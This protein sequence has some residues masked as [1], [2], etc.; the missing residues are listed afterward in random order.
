MVR[1]RGGSGVTCTVLFL[2]HCTLMLRSS[3]ARL[4]T[5]SNG[6]EAGCAGLTCDNAGEKKTDTR[7]SV[8][9]AY[10]AQTA[11]TTAGKKEDTVFVRVRGGGCHDYGRSKAKRIH[12]RAA[13]DAGQCAT[14][15]LGNVL[16]SLYFEYDAGFCGCGELGGNECQGPDMGSNWGGSVYRITSYD[17]SARQIPQ[18]RRSD[19]NKQKHGSEGCADDRE[20]CKLWAS[21]GECEKNP[22]YMKATC[23]A[24][25]GAPGCPVQAAPA[26][27]YLQQNPSGMLFVTTRCAGTAA[28]FERGVLELR[29]WANAE[30][31]AT[32]RK[33]RAKLDRM[34]VTYIMT[35]S[36]ASRNL[37]EIP[38]RVSAIAR[39]I[40][41]IDTDYIDNKRTFGRL[42]RLASNKSVFLFF[43]SCL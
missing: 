32:Q 42:A 34:A 2:L 33:L 35:E 37:A 36:D 23:S 5:C 17:K 16:C 38:G 14:M 13:R 27:L 19:Q 8:G 11:D 4:N 1:A 25:C 3:S 30:G 18:P 7:A 9:L 21:L 20:E 28:M 31:A 12:L 41:K 40:P 29:R 15:V 26:G 6:D 39:L 43:F 24:A 22:G 10:L